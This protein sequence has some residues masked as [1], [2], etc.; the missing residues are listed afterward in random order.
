MHGN[1]VGEEIRILG[2]VKSRLKRRVDRGWL[3]FVSRLQIFNGSFKRALLI[4]SIN[5]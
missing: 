4:S 2:E 5:C 3:N 1:R